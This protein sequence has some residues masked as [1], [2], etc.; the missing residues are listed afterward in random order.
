MKFV[1]WKQLIIADIV[2]LLPIFLGLFLWKS[3]PDAM[4]IHFDINGNPD[5]YAPKGFVVVG[6]PI[7][8]AAVETFCSIVND[9]NVKKYGDGKRIENVTR[10]IIPVVSVVLYLAT[11]GYAMNWN[12]NI[13]QVAVIVVAGAFIAT[14]SCIPKMTHIKNY[15]IAPEKARKI[16][17]FLGNG[18]VIIGVLF[19]ISAFLPQIYTF[20]CLG[21]LI[22]YTIAGIVYGIKVGR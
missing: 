5:N 14:G 6:L 8:M 4:A 17:K 18:L 16:N 13:R 9:Y 11:I 1:K 15:K 22:P 21:L 19:L 7:I 10:W 20:I 12:I 3:L 2:C